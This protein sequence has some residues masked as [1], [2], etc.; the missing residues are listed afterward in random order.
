MTYLYPFQYFC[1]AI[2]DGLPCFK[3]SITSRVPKYQ[4]AATLIYHSHL[5]LL[6]SNT[7]T[8][9]LALP[10]QYFQWGL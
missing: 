1:H 10:F 6:I 4:E 3:L 8:K 7:K 2:S 9:E 5:Y